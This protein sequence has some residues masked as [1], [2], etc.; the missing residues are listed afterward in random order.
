MRA[1]FVRPK[2]GRIGS[3]LQSHRSVI[4]NESI[5]QVNVPTQTLNTPKAHVQIQ[6]LPPLGLSKTEPILPMIEDVFSEGDCK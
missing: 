5:L 6:K 3:H 2:L 1:G 4:N